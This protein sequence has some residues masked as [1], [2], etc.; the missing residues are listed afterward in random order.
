MVGN[1]NKRNVKQLQ[2]AVK[3]FSDQQ[4]IVSFQ[5]TRKVYSV[6][7][8]QKKRYVFSPYSEE[9]EVPTAVDAR[10]LKVAHYNFTVLIIFPQGAVL[11]LQVRQCAQ[12]V[13]CTSAH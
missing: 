11:L 1:S 13:P 12:L 7:L 3:Q 4:V 2:N 6:C 10:D 8:M 5:L 9:G